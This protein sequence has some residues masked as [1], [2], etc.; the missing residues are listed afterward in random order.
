MDTCIVTP[1]LVTSENIGCPDFFLR[2]SLGLTIC[3]DYWLPL[4]YK[5]TSS[6]HMF[7]DYFAL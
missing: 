1:P 2:L 5:I 6:I 7:K 4:N 3:I